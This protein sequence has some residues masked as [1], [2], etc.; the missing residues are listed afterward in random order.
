MAATATKPAEPV[1]AEPVDLE[2][3]LPAIV[4][5]ADGPAIVNSQTGDIES[6]KAEL[7][8]LDTTYAGMSVTPVSDQQAGV[9]MKEATLDELDIKPDSFGAV[10]VSHGGYARRLN[11]AFKPGGWALRQLSPIMLDRAQNRVYVQMALYCEGRYFGMAIGEQEWIGSNSNMS[12]GDAVEGAFS[13]AL[14]RCG[15]RIGMFLE[16]WDRKF[17]ERFRREHCVKV[18]V[19]K[20]HTR[21]VKPAWRR[22]DGPSLEGETGI[23]DDS[24]NRDKYQ[25][26]PAPWWMRN[27]QDREAQPTHTAAAQPTQQA[28]KPTANPD[29]PISQNQAKRLWAI[30]RTKSGIRDEDAAAMITKRWGFK[31]TLEITRG[32]YEE[33][34]NYFEQANYD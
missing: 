1:H 3:A 28:P 27:K 24:P 11:Q 13:N 21:D 18:F 4:P 8:R 6:A 14:M 23:C 15:K 9:L 31:T 19:A 12:Y 29:Q 34:C 32:K 20:V 22:L 10:Y 2:S 26:P 30:V 33:I 25:Q 5:G 7:W 16:C 17:T